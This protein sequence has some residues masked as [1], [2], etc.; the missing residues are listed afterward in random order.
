LILAW[1][2]KAKRQLGDE[3][4]NRIIK[5]EEV[6]TEQALQSEARKQQRSSENK[7]NE[8]YWEFKTNNGT[9]FLKKE[10]DEE[11]HL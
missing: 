11:D 10:S 6:T 2:I 5:L 9:F 8:K 3:T 7:L 4:K 1:A